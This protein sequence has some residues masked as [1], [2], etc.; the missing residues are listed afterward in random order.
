[1]FL[2]PVFAA[3]ICRPSRKQQA[4]L[5]EVIFIARTPGLTHTV[6]WYFVLPGDEMVVNQLIKMHPAAGT[7]PFQ[8]NVRR[9]RTLLQSVLCVHA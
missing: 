8:V 4:L 9:Q 3:H 5:H 6:T 2:P 7:L 1:M